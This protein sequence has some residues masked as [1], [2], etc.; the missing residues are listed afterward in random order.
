MEGGSA[1][2]RRPVLLAKTTSYPCASSDSSGPTSSSPQKPYSE[3]TQSTFF[4]ISVVT[5]MEMRAYQ[6]AET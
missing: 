6:A 1:G 5:S 4:A 3:R 2:G